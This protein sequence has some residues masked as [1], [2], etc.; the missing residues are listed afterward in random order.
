MVFFWIGP[1]LADPLCG[2]KSATLGGPRLSDPEEVEVQIR[3]SP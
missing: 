1:L 3:I 2:K